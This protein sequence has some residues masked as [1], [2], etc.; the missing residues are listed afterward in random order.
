MFDC[1]WS[2]AYAKMY[3]CT[4]L[5][6]GFW[7]STHLNYISNKNWPLLGLQR[8]NLKIEIGLSKRGDIPNYDKV[9][10]WV[11]YPILWGRQADRQTDR[12]T[13]TWT[14]VCMY[15]FSLL[16]WND[17]E[18]SCFPTMFFGSWQGSIRVSRDKFISHLL[19]K[20]LDLSDEGGRGGSLWGYLESTY[21]YT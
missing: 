13:Y 12:H 18:P 14:Y 6:F 9:T 8:Y 5:S 21:G 19:R 15:T 10:S 20:V 3:E 4:V 11:V 17:S 16:N 7:Y 2:S 1:V